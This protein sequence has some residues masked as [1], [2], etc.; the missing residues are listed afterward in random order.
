[1]TRL[2]AITVAL[3]LAGCSTA[4]GRFAAYCNPLTLAVGTVTDGAVP[5]TTAYGPGPDTA[6]F[7]KCRESYLK[8][9]Q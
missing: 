4:G 8:V 5:Y 6:L 7:K 2:I 1:M 3:A 9:T